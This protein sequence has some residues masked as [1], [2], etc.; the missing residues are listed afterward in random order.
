MSTLIQ[1][2][3][4]Q[5]IGILAEKDID[6]WLTF[7]RETSAVPDP[8]LSLIYGSTLTWQSALILTRSGERVA[9]V[10]RF[11]AETARRT[12][13][14]TEVIG[15]DQSI[16][17]ELMR[18]LERFDPGRMA[19]NTSIHDCT[20]DGLTHG[21]YQVLQGYLAGSP[22]A[23]R[24]V[25]AEGIISALIGR[26]TAEEINRVT[27]AVVTT[28]EIYRRTFEYL[29]PG[30]S[31]KQVAAFMHQQVQAL[32]VSESWD[33]DGCPIINSGPQ[34]SV[35]HTTPTDIKLERGHL[36]HFDFGIRQNGYCSDIQ[37]MV[38]LLREGE[39]EAPEPVRRAFETVER[40]TRE[41]GAAMKPGITGAQVDAIA[42]RIIM[43]A[44]YPEFMHAT[45]HQLGRSAH[46]GAGILGPKWERYGATPDYPLEAGQVYTIE[47]GA[48]VPGYGYIGLE[49]DVVLTE[50]GARYL[51]QPQQ[52]LILL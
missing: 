36:V 15:Y 38:Y 13:A 33:Y 3:V 25:S 14:Y 47:P 52:A 46:D 6:L 31:E 17:P 27:Q 19:I 28:E 8:V 35:G 45:G 20:A 5:A 34:S 12:G 10:G 50:T 16:Q 4:N 42:R 48:P 29:R 1:E 49:E 41:A 43:E 22:L 40:A 11:E 32:G 9:I 7:V 37:R 51:S 18:A 26:K 24:L 21:M 23:G 30:M 44:G 39:K 2:K